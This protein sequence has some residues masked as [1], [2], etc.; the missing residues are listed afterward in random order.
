M[1]TVPS[2]LQSLDV[3]ILYPYYL[4]GSLWNWCC[5]LFVP[6]FA[7]VY[8]IL[9]LSSQRCSLVQ[10]KGQSETVAVNVEDMGRL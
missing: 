1:R 3:M 5:F 7:A 10:G 9:S 4:S 6:S 2:S 8:N